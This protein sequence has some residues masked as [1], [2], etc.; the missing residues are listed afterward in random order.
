LAQT[1]NSGLTRANVEVKGLY[2]S[3]NG[4]DISYYDAKE[5]A[6]TNGTYTKS[7]EY[8]ITEFRSKTNLIRISFELKSSS[9][10]YF[11]RARIY[12]NGVAVGTERQIASTA[13]STFVE[14]LEFADGDLI[15]I[16]QNAVASPAT[17]STVKNFQIVGL[18][19]QYTPPIEIT[20]A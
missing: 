11:A 3:E 10:S 19:S 6:V 1:I 5:T 20:K 18:I 15:Q 2:L 13:Y 7:R 4:T 17:T 16:Y 9:G 8:E 12:K 14:D